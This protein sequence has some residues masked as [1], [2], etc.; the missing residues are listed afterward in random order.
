MI[1]FF[2]GKAATGKTKVAQII[3]DQKGFITISKDEVFDEL[4][5]QGIEW[6][7]ANS[8]TYNKLAETIQRH[9]D[10][11]FDAIVDIGLAHTPY[12]SKFLSKMNL[13]KGN[14]K[15]FLFV[16]SKGDLWEKRIAHR[17]RSPEAP[18][19]FFK[20]INEAIE[21]YSKYNIYTLSDEI[22]IDSALSVEAMIDK[23]YE[24]I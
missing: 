19:Q 17:I 13:G 4:L 21:H 1:Y 15:F 16:C 23:I 7:S 5:N 6:D 24:V 3:K 20:S 12:F 18:N 22:E 9:H 11:G 8:L 2:R 14:V 10:E